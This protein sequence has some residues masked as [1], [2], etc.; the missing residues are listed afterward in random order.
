MLIHSNWIPYVEDV[1]THAATYLAQNI[2]R[3]KHLRKEW[4]KNKKTLDDQA[5][6]QIEAELQRSINMKG[7]GG[8]SHSER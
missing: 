8:I 7:G 3:I 4:A 1:E 6:T 5:L 2:S